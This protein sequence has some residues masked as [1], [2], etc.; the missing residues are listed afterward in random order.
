[1]SSFINNIKNKFKNIFEEE[2]ETYFSNDVNINKFS[3]S[4]I[5]DL[6]SLRI[7]KE[8]F[9][10]NNFSLKEIETLEHNA[11]NLLISQIE[12][13]KNNTQVEVGVIGSFSSGKSTFINS[14]FGEAICPMAVKP[15]TS[16]ITKFYYGDKEKISING[17]EIT[18][19]EYH[20]SSQHLKG[21]TQ[22]TQTHYIEY[23]YPFE[24]LNS[25]VLYDTPGFNNNLNEN[26]TDVTMKALLSVDVIFFI[27]DISKGAID[28][29]SIERL[30]KFKDKRMYC[31]LNK[32]DLKSEQAISKIKNEIVSEKLFLEV[33]EYSAFK[34]LEFGKKD[35]FRDYVNHIENNLISKK[36]DFTSNVQGVG[37]EIKGRLKTKFEYK[38][39]I[40]NNEVT[41]DNFYVLAKNQRVRIE[42]MLNKI[43]ES[44]QS[45]FQQK[46]K[47]DKYH[48]NQESIS[49]IKKEL[50]KLKN[51]GNVGKFKKFE[52]DIQK[53]EDELYQFEEK[54]I[55]TFYKEWNYS[56]KTSCTI[57]NVSNE[58]KPF[59]STPYNKIY[60]N[61]IVFKGKIKKI[62]TLRSIEHLFAERIKFFKNFYNIE[63]INVDFKED[64][65]EEALPWY[66][67]FYSSSNYL[68]KEGEGI[69]FE[70]RLEAREYLETFLDFEHKNVITS[71]RSFLDENEENIEKYKREFHTQDSEKNKSIDSLKKEL[72]KFIK[73][74]EA[75]VKSLQR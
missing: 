43:S 45:T 23:A 13:E 14:L 69:Y 2:Q 41:I 18:Q 63:L 71:I 33:I 16:S 27:V 39:C 48:Y 61:K 49:L 73:E 5:K 1:M 40:D 52:Q 6:A 42:R 24:R 55:D 31:I 68:E 60:F 17:R 3:E 8:L 26:D 20:N 22:N 37:K 38:L 4:M 74:K 15:T 34:V 21:D 28:L 59:W 32:S 36:I 30:R 7:I 70:D 56:F 50:E 57:E 65:A 12:F 46:L 67:N 11:F 29:S 35:Y 25:I 44:K 10:E 51:Q 58:E 62:D 72:N 19:N 75:Y 53:L 47:F 66:S 9:K 54:H 64:M